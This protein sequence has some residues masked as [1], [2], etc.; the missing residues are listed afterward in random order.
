MNAKYNLSRSAAVLGASAVALVGGVVGA[1]KATEAY[2]DHEPHQVVDGKEF[3]YPD[4]N[5]SGLRSEYLLWGECKDLSQ[6][7]IDRVARIAIGKKSGDAQLT[8]DREAMPDVCEKYVDRETATVELWTKRS[9]QKEWHKDHDQT[10]TNINN[11]GREN[12]RIR[13]DVG[14]CVPG[15]TMKIDTRVK[16]AA[17]NTTYVPR[18][19]GGDK[20]GEVYK[21]WETRYPI[22]KTKCPR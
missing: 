5:P 21:E 14:R 22:M 19:L 12:Y 7:S 2:G 18:E 8:V 13:A 17:I 15:R 9:G 20:P 11:K 3:G 1:V 6:R 4:K 10:E 16:T